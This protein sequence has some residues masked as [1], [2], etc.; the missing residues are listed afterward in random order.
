MIKKFSEMGT[1]PSVIYMEGG[2]ADDKV[3]YDMCN[4]KDIKVMPVE[5]WR[6][7]AGI[8]A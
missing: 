1:L 8:Y 7:L 2:G 3:C 5:L 6:F 4:E